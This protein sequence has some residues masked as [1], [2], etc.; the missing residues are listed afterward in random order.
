MPKQITPA[1]FR[2]YGKIIHYPDIHNKD[3]K[4]NLFR[5]VLSESEGH[6]WRI[7]YLVVRDRSII[8][9]ERHPGTFETFE[10]VKGRALLYVSSGRD[11]RKIDCFL[12]DKPI[13]LFK[14]I[15]HGVVAVDNE[16]EIKITENAV[17]SSEYW[18]TGLRLNGV[19]RKKA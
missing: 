4:K 8:D 5:I 10:P 15:W 7:A 11:A 14:G 1:S 18:R 16:A 19:F 12:L 6:G 2:K 3:K 9:L 17:V 13:V